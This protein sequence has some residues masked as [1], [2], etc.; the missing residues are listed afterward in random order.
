MNKRKLFPILNHSYNSQGIITPPKFLKYKGYNRKLGFPKICIITS[1]KNII[2][3]FRKTY[4]VKAYKQWISNRS[5]LYVFRIKNK[6]GNKSI[7]II[8]VGLGAPQA[9][10]LGEMLIECGA[11]KF[12]II[13]SA[14][15]IQKD[16][17]INDF[18]LVKKAIR[19][20]GCSYHYLAP[21]KYVE[22][23]SKLYQSL[24]KFLSNQRIKFKSGVI[25]TTDAFYRGTKKEVI[26]YQKEGVL[27]IDME[28]A[29]LFA[30][31]KYRKVEAA[32]LLYISD[33]VA[34]LVWEPHLYESGTKR[35]QKE[36]AKLI[37]SYLTSL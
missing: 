8:N 22:T 36:I 2:D 15:T 37:I 21:G 12:F 25:W 20:E 26:K 9:V 11:R 13:G 7:G 14:G 5:K 32:A 16:L 6:I 29:A 28:T 17:E 34:D 18:I 24:K 23:S 31:A 19:D 1:Q 10:T 30:L 3:F 4:K 27:A 33:S 35:T